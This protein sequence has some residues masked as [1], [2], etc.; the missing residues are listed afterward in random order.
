MDTCIPLPIATRG[1]STKCTIFCGSNFYY[2]GQIQFDVL[3]GENFE[4]FL[5]EMAV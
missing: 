4:N 2:G 5:L 3:I 1:S